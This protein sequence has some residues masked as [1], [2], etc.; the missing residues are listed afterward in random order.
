MNLYFSGMDIIGVQ[1]IYVGNASLHR[2]TEPGK[3][4]AQATPNDE[5]NQ[6]ETHTNSH[7]HTLQLHKL[8]VI[9]KNVISSLKNKDTN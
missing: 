4:L 5:P 9:F 2:V 6:K 1:F 3:K 7:I 8:Y